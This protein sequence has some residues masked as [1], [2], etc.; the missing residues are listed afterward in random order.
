MFARR[1]GSSDPFAKE[2][3]KKGADPKVDPEVWR[4]VED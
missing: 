2:R 1:R 3:T 4:E